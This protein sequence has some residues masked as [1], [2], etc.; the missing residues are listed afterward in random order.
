MSDHPIISIRSVGKRFPG[1]I[2]LAGVTLD[3]RAGELQAVDTRL[4][5]R[6]LL[7]ADEA[8]QH[9]FRTDTRGDYTAEVIAQHVAD[10]GVRGLMVDPGTLDVLLAGSA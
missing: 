7:A 3:V 6:T 8:T 9:W 4:A 2:A 10:V 5:A 1:V